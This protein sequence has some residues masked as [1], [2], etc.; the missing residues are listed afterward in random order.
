MPLVTGNSLA[1]LRAKIKERSSFDIESAPV[2]VT[3]TPRPGLWGSPGS[4]TCAP[5]DVSF[6][7]RTVT[8]ER[9]QWWLLAVRFQ[10]AFPP[11]RAVRNLQRA[12]WSLELPPGCAQ[13]SGQQAAPRPSEG[14][15]TAHLPPCPWSLQTKPLLPVISLGFGQHTRPFVVQCPQLPV[16]PRRGPGCFGGWKQRDGEYLS[17]HSQ[18]LLS[19][20]T[21]QSKRWPLA[22]VS[23][24]FSLGRTVR[25][26]GPTP[27]ILRW[28]WRLK[29][30]QGPQ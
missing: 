16:S 9:P 19:L 28:G 10:D 23:S 3:R 14:R 1:L 4:L 11:P 13:V 29:A 26:W 20:Q 17:C 30:V 22:R 21:Q 24:S 7:Q 6:L 12:S 18:A 27:F 5:S 2:T 15:K 25:L 8:A